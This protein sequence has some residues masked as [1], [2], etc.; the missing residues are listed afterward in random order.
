MPSFPSLAQE[1][2]RKGRIR[3]LPYYLHN[4]KKWITTL[5]AAMTMTIN[6]NAQ[7]GV[8]VKD[9]HTDEFATIISDTSK[10]QLVD[11]RTPEEYAEGH[12]EG[13]VNIDVNDS[14]F[15]QHATASLEKGRA[16]AVY[17]RSGKRSALAA[18][19]LAKQGY[20][21]INLLGGILAWKEDRRPIVK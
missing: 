18:S 10:T 12:L 7:S 19:L 15:L 9:V 14:T 20:N 21:V 11:V 3:Q 2:D 8:T 1:A 5:L 16:V 6:S 17:C 4:M 13:A